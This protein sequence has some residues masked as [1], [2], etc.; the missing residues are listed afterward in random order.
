MYERMNLFILMKEEHIHPKG[1]MKGEQGEAPLR[2]NEL[3]WMK[4]AS[5]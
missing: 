5:L 2:V 4:G 1:W 3:G